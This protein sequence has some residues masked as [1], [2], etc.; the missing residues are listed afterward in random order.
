M[1]EIRDG[2]FETNSSSCHVFIYHTNQNVSFP[3]VVI[4]TPNSDDSPLDILFNDYYCWYDFSS[5]FVDDMSRFLSRLKKA[6]VKTVKCSDKRIVNLFSAV[7]PYGDISALP[8]IISGNVEVETM[9]DYLVDSDT[10]KRD[11]GEDAS[12]FS[13]RLS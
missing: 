13:I 10:I 12:Y 6:G 4:L 11:H 7:E 2:F 3:K 8:Y 5:D 1:I 9:E